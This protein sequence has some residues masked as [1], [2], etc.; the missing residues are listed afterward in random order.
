MLLSTIFLKR[1][2]LRLEKRREASL[3]VQVA[4]KS[5]GRELLH[6]RLV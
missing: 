3:S 2:E 4:L 5:K 6:F 1:L